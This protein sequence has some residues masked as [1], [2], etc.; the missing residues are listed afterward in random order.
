MIT[1]LVRY[2]LLSS[3]TFQTT[4]DVRLIVDPVLYRWLNG[5]VFKSNYLGHTACMQSDWKELSNRGFK[6]MYFLWENSQCVYVGITNCLTS[7]IGAHI[8]G[9]K[10]FTHISFIRVKVGV[11][12]SV[13]THFIKTLSPKY[14]IVGNSRY[15]YKRSYN[16]EAA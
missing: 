9:G 7:R 12:N 6:V 5:R 11:A 2:P 4:T 15:S 8:R 16:R 14:N 10:Y 13:E 3:S 1:S